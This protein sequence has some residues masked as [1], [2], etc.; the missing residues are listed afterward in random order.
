MVRSAAWSLRR[1][2][3]K[4]YLRRP[5][6][7]RPPRT[8]ATVSLRAGTSRSLRLRALVLARRI[9]GSSRLAAYRP[10]AGVRSP[11]LCPAEGRCEAGADS[12]DRSRRLP[13]G[14]LTF[15]TTPDLRI[16][17]YVLLP[18]QARV[19]RLQSSSSTAT[20]A[21]TSG[22]RKRSSPSSRSI[23][24]W[25]RSSSSATAVRA[26]PRSWRGAVT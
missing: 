16:P 6:P 23:P 12:P 11:V 19:R 7:Q 22:A 2:M 4:W 18:K 25:R 3:E 21:S 14:V 24:I 17:A 1:R 10:G 9:Q 5:H 15:Q 26:S 8:S 20:T 13:R